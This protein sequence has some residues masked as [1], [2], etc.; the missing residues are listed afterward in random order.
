VKTR[1]I[2]VDAARP[3]P[4][5]LADAVRVLRDGGVVAFPTE[6]FYGLGAAALNRDAVHRI[7]ELKGRPR[8]SPLLVLVDSVEMAE[9]IATIPDS[10][11]PLIARHWPGAL[12]LVFTARNVVPEEIAASTGTVGVRVSAHPIACALV[13]TLGEPLTAPSANVTGQAPPPTAAAV[14]RFFD[15]AI[16]LILDG[17]ETP[18]GLPSTVLD[19][20]VDPPRVIRHGAVTP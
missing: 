6:T 15:Q 13:R 8:S 9:R 18:G 17:G 1:R 16:E 20:T 4:R 12:T 14:L 19:V 7:F 11:R 3:D 2:A 5:T 10:A